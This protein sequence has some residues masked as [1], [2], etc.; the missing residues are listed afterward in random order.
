MNIAYLRELGFGSGLVQHLSNHDASSLLGFRCQPPHYWRSSPI[1]ARPILPLWECG[2]TLVYFHRERRLF[3]KCSLED[4]DNV[5]L[6]HK[7]VQ[8]ILADLLVDLYEDELTDEALRVAAETLGFK[9]IERFLA[10]VTVEHSDQNGRFRA[11]K[12]W[13]EQFCAAYTD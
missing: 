12:H 7:S 1:S 11:Y 4:I 5:W 6:Q 2:T 10:T 13:R 8:A 9:H 3:E